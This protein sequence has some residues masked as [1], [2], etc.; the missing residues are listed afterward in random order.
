M[1]IPSASS[2]ER[3]RGRR[4]LLPLT[5]CALVSVLLF[6]LAERAS[7]APTAAPVST[8]PGSFQV[9]EATIGGIHRAILAHHLTSV[10]LVKAYL[11]RIKAYNGRSV[12][13]PEGI[14]GPIKTIPHAGQI[15]ALQTLNLRPAARKAWGFDDRKARSMT[16]A[17]DN[18]PAMPDALEIAAELDR[19][20]AETG[21]LVGPLHGVVIAVKDQYDTFDLRT[22]AGADAF[23]ANDRPPRD[24]TFVKKLREAGAI[25]LAKSNLGEYASGIPR[26]SFGGTFSNPYDTERS[27]MGSS[28]GSGTAV[29]ANLVTCAIGEETGT[30][31]RGPASYNNCVGIAGTQELV[32]RDGMMGA[33]INTRCGPICR[34]VEDAAR[35]LSVIAGYDPKDEMTAFNVGRL[36]DQPYQEFTHTRS[37]KGLR[38]GVVREYMDKSAFTVADVESIDLVDRAIEDLRKLGATIVDPGADGLFTDAIRRYHPQVHNAQFTKK[39]PTQFPVDAA[40]KPTSDHVAVLIEMGLDPK[41]LPEKVTIRDLGQARAEGESKYMLNRYLAERGDAQI[42]TIDDLL[43]KARFFNDEH[44]G[45]RKKNLVNNNK[46]L[47]LDTAVRM[48]RRFAVQQF[49]LLAMAEMKLDAI[50]YPTGNLPPPKLG[51]PMEPVVNGRNAIWS[52]LGG[53]G[54][55]AITVPAGFTTQVYD[56]VVDPTAPRVPSSAPGADPGETV[57]GSKQ[58]GPV[59]AKLPVGVDFMG[60]PFSEP[61]LLRIAAAYEEATKHRT[62]PPDFG[63]VAGEL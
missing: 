51:A 46:P 53:Q 19:K 22:T 7:A 3:V 6:P 62:P 14:L 16:D 58:V 42:K 61:V 8:V 28:S 45:D 55:P 39:Y 5:A 4:L 63:P 13:E 9:E 40:G 57:E 44:F 10:Q 49:V 38:I 29:A 1:S 12:E 21:K 15:N 59:A 50:V 36:P 43:T 37:L 54:F 17:E 18:N 11:T 56:R 47:A 52:F 30:S 48:Q 35:I 34:T 26:S 2:S 27:P 32:S 41:K 24:A 33:G 23:Y 20:F 31:I 60:R 25:I